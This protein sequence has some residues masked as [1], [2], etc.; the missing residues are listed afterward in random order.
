MRKFFPGGGRA[1]GSAPGA[2]LAGRAP[3]VN[4]KTAKNA[5]RQKASALFYSQ[6]KYFARIALNR[7]GAARRTRLAR[8][9]SKI[10]RCAVATT[11]ESSHALLCL[12]GNVT[13]RSRF[14]LIA[15]DAR[16]CVAFATDALPLCG[17]QRAAQNPK[18]FETSRAK[19]YASN[20]CAAICSFVLALFRLYPH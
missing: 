19:Y 5:T 18:S 2:T 3:R 15:S 20:A 17:G 13:L 6:L 9:D 7:R 8:G 10:Y 16:F 11:S 1:R 4:A 12:C 14:A